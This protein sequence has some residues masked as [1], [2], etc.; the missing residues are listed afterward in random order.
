MEKFKLFLKLYAPVF[1]RFGMAMVVLWFGFEQFMNAS[2]WTAYVP[3]SAVAMSHVSA[4]TLVYFNATF[5][6]LF[7]ILLIIGWKVRIV[8]LLISLH[9][10]NIMFVVGYNETGVRDFGLAVAILAIAMNGSD[11]LCMKKKEDVPAVT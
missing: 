4:E 6:V 8:A 3:D 5:E 10:F 2:S 9:L 1:L 11:V 7:G